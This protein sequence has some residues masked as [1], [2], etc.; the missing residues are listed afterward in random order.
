LERYT[1]LNE[2]DLTGRE[3]LT[4]ILKGTKPYDWTNNFLEFS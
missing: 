1:R 3:L 2:M 4:F